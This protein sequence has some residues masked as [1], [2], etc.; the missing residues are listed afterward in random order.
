MKKIFMPLIIMMLALM[1]TASGSFAANSI[2]ASAY[3]AGDMVQIT[4]KIAPGEE[5]YIAIAQQDMFAPK[6]TTG[7]HE[8]KTFKKESQ[9]RGFSLDTQIPPLYY[10]I[11][12][13][14]EKFGKVDKK[15]IRWTFCPAGQRQWHLQHHHVLSEKRNK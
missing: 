14:P 13:V 6:D 8:I 11:T 10:M 5:L 12:T 1:F 2:S 4:G 15:K 7:V 3:K 9:K